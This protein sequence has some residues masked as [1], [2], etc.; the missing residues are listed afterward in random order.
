MKF[1]TDIKGVIFD[2]DGVLL[3]SL[4]I[5][6]DLGSNY[7]RGIGVEPEEGLGSI[8][9]DMSMEQGVAYLKKHYALELSEKEIR[10]G[11]TTMLRDFYF[12]EAR[13]KKGAAELLGGLKNSG[14]HLT[15]ATET[16]E[17]LVKYA[18]RRNGLLAFFERIFVCSEIGRS[19]KD[20]TIFDA[21][22]AFMGTGR[23][24]TCVI[25]DSL[26]A[27]KAAAEAGY[28]TVG[29][30]NDNGEPNQEELKRTAELYIRDL[31][32]LRE[33]L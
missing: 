1:G 26:Y 12:Y 30:R 10:H 17:E 6:K 8:L 9:Y 21:A 5:W 20:G 28:H 27:L 25:E 16:P 32:E 23:K 18:L 24:E 13:P 33:Y 11:F 31:D 7:L 22:A 19:K 15:A 14:V 29:V 2:L 4:G 3:D